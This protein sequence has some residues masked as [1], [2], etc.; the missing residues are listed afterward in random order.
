MKQAADLDRVLEDH[1]VAQVSV[2]GLSWADVAFQAQ[3]LQVWHE[4]RFVGAALKVFGALC[5]EH[6]IALEEMRYDMGQRNRD[7]RALHM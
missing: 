5:D 3:R 2:L 1:R 7:S 4:S 6:I